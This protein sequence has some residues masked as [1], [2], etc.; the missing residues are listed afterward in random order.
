QPRSK[1][2]PIDSSYGTS[3]LITTRFLFRNIAARGLLARIPQFAHA[4][5][6]DVPHHD[7]ARVEISDA[8]RRRLMDALAAV[9][10]P[11]LARRR[12]GVDS[13]SCP[14]FQESSSPAVSHVR[15]K[16]LRRG[17][18][19]GKLPGGLVA[20]EEIVQAVCQSARVPPGHVVPR[21]RRYGRARPRSSRMR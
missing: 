11:L 8:V 19:G 7:I 12:R 3:R 20:D 10:L 15:P 6:Q 13:G 16:R 17:R 9:L 4:T 14:K 21:R 5:L 2:A 18:R 1:A